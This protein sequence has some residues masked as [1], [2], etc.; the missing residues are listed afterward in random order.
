MNDEDRRGSGDQGDDV[1]TKN[2]VAP[3]E[4]DCEAG[5]YLDADEAR[6]AGLV[7]EIADRGAEVYRWPPRGFGFR[8]NPAR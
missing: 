6:R 3:I 2:D 5:R 7:D 4:A 8:P 1:M